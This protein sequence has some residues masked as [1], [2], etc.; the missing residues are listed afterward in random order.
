MKCRDDK[1]R[2]HQ[3]IS[4]NLLDDDEIESV[5][6]NTESFLENVEDVLHSLDSQ[7]DDSEK[8]DVPQTFNVLN[9]K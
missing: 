2:K 1:K 6:N 8:G 3:Q 9:V 4:S 7:L 5:I